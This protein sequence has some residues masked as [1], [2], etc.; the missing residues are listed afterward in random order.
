MIYQ[1]LA[2]DIKLEEFIKHKNIQ[3]HSHQ[4]GD[5]MTYHIAFGELCYIVIKE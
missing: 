1:Q 4:S 5:I 2:L 3:A